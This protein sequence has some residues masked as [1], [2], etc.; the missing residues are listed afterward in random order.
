MLAITTSSKIIPEANR[1][2]MTTAAA[3]L[4]QLNPRSLSHTEKVK[5]DVPTVPSPQPTTSEPHAEPTH[6]AME[7]KGE[8]R[9][10][11]ARPKVSFLQQGESNGDLFS[12]ENRHK[13]V[14]GI[15]LG[16]VFVAVFVAMGIGLAAQAASDKAK[17]GR[18]GGSRGIFSNLMTPNDEDRTPPELRG[19][20][21]PNFVQPKN[22]DLGGLNGG[23]TGQNGSRFTQV[24][25]FSLINITLLTPLK[26]SVQRFG[27]LIEGSINYQG[28]GAELQPLPLR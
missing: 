4:N 10:P 19:S 1:P 6:P 18:A 5:E 12:G 9:P 15:V 26:A 25:Y 14:L 2:L 17:Q 22:Y 21:A 24:V 13:A 7:K 20:G 23:T 27:G 16:V 11:P 28:R 8:A 3:D